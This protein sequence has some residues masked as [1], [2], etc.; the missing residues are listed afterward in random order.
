[1]TRTGGAT[2]RQEA[3]ALLD[4]PRL[5][6]GGSD[7]ALERLRR[8]R[9]DPRDAAVHGHARPPHPVARV[10]P[11]AGRD[12]ARLPRRSRGALAAPLVTARTR[13]RL[14]RRSDLVR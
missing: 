9:I 2:R 3:S 14:A 5:L 4:D 11:A 13:A 8:Y 10:R 7:H 1:M 6:A 12:G